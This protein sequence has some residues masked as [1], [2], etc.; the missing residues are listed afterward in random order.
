MNTVTTQPKSYKVL[1]T[2]SGTGSRLAPLTTYTNKALIHVGRKP[3]LSHIIEAY[4]AS[5]ALVITVGHH[6]NLV[7]EFV[8]LVYPD[9]DITFVNVQRYQG[10]GTSLALSM[11]QARDSLQCPFIFHACDTIVNEDVI[12]APNH[13][14]VAFLPSQDAK[15]YMSLRVRD[16]QL[17]ALEPKGAS[18]ANKIHIGLVGIQDYQD[19]WQALDNKY[20]AHPNDASLNDASGVNL[21]LQQ[22]HS[23]YTWPVTQWL[24]I[25]NHDSLDQARQAI[26]DPWS[27]V[28]EKDQEA[29]YLIEDNVVKFYSEPKIIEQRVKRAGHL[30]PLV[31]TITGQTDHFFM[32]QHQR[33]QVLSHLITPQSTRQLLD[34]A[35]QH[36]WQPVNP[37][38]SPATFQAA[39][40]QFYKTKTEQRLNA[41]FASTDLTDQVDTV[42]GQSIPPIA[43]LL[44]QIDWDALCDSSP[45]NWHG[46]FVLDNILKVKRGYCLIDW[47]QDFAGLLN[48]GDKYYDFAKLNH[49]L[50]LN[51][52]IINQA[53]FTFEQDAQG[54]HCD[55]LRHHNMVL[56]QQELHHWL[57]EHNINRAKVELLT[58]LNWLNGAALHQDPYRH[59]LFYFGKL[60]LWRHLTQSNS[61]TSF[62]TSMAFS[63]PGNSSTLPRGNSPR[64]S[65]PTTPTG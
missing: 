37:P 33:G 12:P 41:L 45:T 18:D 65:E 11:L 17:L 8:S 15:Q 42:N 22:G 21:L 1:I 49:N 13:N 62:S 4:P 10:P 56:C 2:T 51:H 39:C 57:D 3:T 7:K 23:F 19:F 38:V 47:R 55:I 64:F 32:Y 46:D 40:R 34:W 24:D 58:A 31:P 43:E 54:I 59:F 50:T 63:Q 6:A 29:I 44:E 35:N 20:Q 9:R 5:V 36:L 14:W 53:L 52:D 28:L 48:A 30:T 26:P 61:A 60:H 16:Q 25:G 27:N